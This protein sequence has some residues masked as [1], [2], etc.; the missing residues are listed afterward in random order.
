MPHLYLSDET[1]DDYD[2]IADTRA[3]YESGLACDDFME[4]DE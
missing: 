4:R 2:A 1:P 3:D